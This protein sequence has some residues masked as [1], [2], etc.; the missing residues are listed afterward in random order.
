MPHITFCSVPV[1]S[2]VSLINHYN[3]VFCSYYLFPFHPQFK[4]EL[5]ELV[6]QSSYSSWFR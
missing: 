5:F 4:L 2:V 6:H 3:S 1:N